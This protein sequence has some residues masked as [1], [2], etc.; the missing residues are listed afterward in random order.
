MKSNMFAFSKHVWVS[1]HVYWSKSLF[2]W[3]SKWSV[4]SIG[5]F[6]TIRIW[7][8]RMEKGS[9]GGTLNFPRGR[10][11][12]NSGFE[13]Q[14]WTFEGCFETK[15]TFKNILE[16]SALIPAQFPYIKSSFSSK[17]DE[18]RWKSSKIEKNRIKISVW[19]PLLGSYLEVPMLRGDFLAA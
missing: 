10:N 11:S 6:S 17:I 7:K 5:T 13:V 12:R 2:Y 19:G 9:Y 3:K 18:N 14:N 8:F 15:M 16:D 4:W 1:I